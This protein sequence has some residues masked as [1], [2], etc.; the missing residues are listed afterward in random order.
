MDTGT[1]PASEP[2]RSVRLR[3]L[4]IDLQVSKTKCDEYRNLLLSLSGEGPGVNVADAT[5]SN[6]LQPA[7]RRPQLRATSQPSNSAP[8]RPERTIRAS[9]RVVEAAIP[10]SPRLARRLTRSQ[11]A[12]TSARQDNGSKATS[13]HVSTI[14]ESNG[15]S[16]GNE[17]AIDVTQREAI[18]AMCSGR[19]TRYAMT[20]A[21]SERAKATP[22][23]SRP[24]L[25]TIFGGECMSEWVKCDRQ[26]NYT[27]MFYAK[28]IAQPFAPTTTGDSVCSMYS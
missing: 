13:S 23:L 3:I 1:P 6:S 24:S 17:V 14:S 11:V 19:V 15:S 16:H 25:F 26:Q 27:K 9:R 12:S 28:V 10:A 4:E 18:E 7:S 5:T 21:E 20:W 8:A 2:A 22:K